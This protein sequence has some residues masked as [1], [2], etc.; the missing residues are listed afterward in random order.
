MRWLIAEDSL[1]TRKGHWFEYLEGFHS[2]LPRLGD[3]VALLVSRRAEPFIREQLDG[4]PLLPESAYLKMGDGARLLRRYARI[5]VHALRTYAAVRRFLAR[6]REPDVIFV[7]TVIVHHLLAWTALTKG[8]LRRRRSRVLLFFPGLPI[9]MSGDSMALDG[10]PTSRL[11]RRLLHSLRKEVAAGRV[12]LGVE[13][14][15]MRHAAETV[16]GL[17]FT[18]FPHPVRP[19]APGPPTSPPHPP[20]ALTLACYGEARHEKGSDVLASAILAHLGRFPAS[21]VRFVLQWIGDFPTP[22]GAMARVPEALRC[23]PRVEIIDR[24]F[25]D[26]EHARRLASTHGLLLPYRRSSYGLRVS[27][28][29]IEAMVQGLPVVATEG[30]TLWEQACQFGAA[31]PCRDGDV[32]SLTD[33]VCGL[34]RDYAALRSQAEIR[35]AEARAH[36]SVG[37]FRETLCRHLSET[38]DRPLSTSGTGACLARE[39]PRRG[40]TQG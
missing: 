5:P 10:S 16:F 19:L 13:A 21:R 40:S 12:V 31:T 38:A 7:P 25:G 8:L 11:M 6:E 24:Y 2:E 4:V 14:Q 9:V 34:E 29:A 35:K 37:T 27:R 17:P 26:G 32:D 3:E 28:V 18:Y 33:A 23:H 39:V 15:A 1:Q 20:S 36:F 30:T 22:G